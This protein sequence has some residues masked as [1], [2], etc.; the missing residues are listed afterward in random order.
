MNARLSHAFEGISA[1]VQDIVPTRW[2]PI[3]ARHRWSLGAAAVA[4]FA[5]LVWYLFFFTPSTPAPK[6]RAV[7]VTAAKAMVQDVPVSITGLGAAQAWTSVTILAQVSGKL[8][9]VDFS[10]GTDV[11]AGQLLAQIDPAPYR[12]ALTQADGALQRDEA[13]LADARLDLARYRALEAENAISRQQA[14]TQAALVKQDQGT[15][16]IDKGLVA[17]ANVNLNWCRITSPISGRV[18]V[19]LVDAGNLVSASG[20]VSNTPSTAA[21]TNAS[22]PTGSSNGGSGIVIVNQIQPIAVTFTVPEGEF[23]RLT[24][25]SDGF[26]KPLVA[27]ALSQETGALLDSGELRISDNRV[28]PT[29]GTVELKARFPN[30]GNRLWPGQFVNVQLMIQILSRATTIPVAA[31]NQGPDGSFLYVVGADR[32]V[33]MRPVAVAWTDGTVAAIKSGIRPGETVVTDGQMILKPG[34]LVR[35]VRSPPATRQSS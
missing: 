28:D 34:S 3:I 2:R 24:T 6:V 1:G 29:T 5:A 15:V 21:A 26:R 30:T 19:R 23:Q 20:S 22:A 18:G 9:S 13:L 11:K 12:A 10:E 8:L 31:V 4:L 33:S 16:L 14:D 25:L 27:K 35:I 32:T 7:P 17:A